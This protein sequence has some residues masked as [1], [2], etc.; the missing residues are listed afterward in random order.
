MR[1]SSSKLSFFFLLFSGFI[2]WISYGFVFP[3]FAFLI[4]SRELLLFPIDTSDIIRGFWLGILL[5][6]SP[7]AQFFSS[8]FLGIISDEKGR[9]SIL[10]YMFILIVIGY[11]VS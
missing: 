11:F 5:A 3:L 1:S 7:L 2:N 10:I 8:P 9:K 4:F 6:V